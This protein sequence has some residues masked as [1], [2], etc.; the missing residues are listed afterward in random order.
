MDDLPKP[1]SEYEEAHQEF[2]KG[3]DDV[4]RLARWDA[5]NRGI[6]A[7]YE[8]IP[9]EQRSEILTEFYRRAKM[10]LE[11]LK[12]DLRGTKPSKTP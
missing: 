11:G 5:R 7:T 2:L 10:E 6:V 3:K 1:T 9:K 4:K 8:K 12:I